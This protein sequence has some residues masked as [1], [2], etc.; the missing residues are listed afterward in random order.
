ME[1]DKNIEVEW[2]VPDFLSVLGDDY[3]KEFAVAE[4]SSKKSYSPFSSGYSRS[5]ENY[6]Q[7]IKAIGFTNKANLLDAGCGMGQ[8]S[9]CFS[10]LNHNVIGIDQS[11]HRL[12]IAKYLNRHNKNVSFHQCNLENIC[13]D[14]ASVDAIFCY[15]VFMFTDMRKTL[16][17]F[18]RVLADDGVIFVNFNNI[19]HYVHR[20]AY[21]L[22]EKKNEELVLQYQNMVANYYRGVYKSSLM[23]L[24]VFSVMLQ[25]I[26]MQI[27][28]S[29]YDGESANL[30]FYRREFYN[31]PYVTE[32]LIKHM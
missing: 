2:N 3:S 22:N 21:H 1:W 30:P 20:I 10:N 16:L 18:K 26:N 23:T 12:S 28:Y 13:M 27:F 19:G 7:R 8:W 25:E 9:Y 32:V 17:E 11:V 4:F 15:G 6:Y 24:E 31:F 14:S 29:G 5:K